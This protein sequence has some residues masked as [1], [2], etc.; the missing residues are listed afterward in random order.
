[1]SDADYRGAIYD[2]AYQGAPGAFSEDASR[3]LLGAAATLL[4]CNSLEDVFR[5]VVDG[6]ASCGVIPISNSIAGAVPDVDALLQ[7]RA[8]TTRGEISVRI[9]QALVGLGGAKVSDIRRVFSHPVALAQCRRFFQ[10]H[11]GLTPQPAFDTAGA[12]AELVRR[13]C[14]SDAAIA[15]VRAA[16]RWGA[17]VLCEDIQD[18]ADNFTRFVRIERNSSRIDAACRRA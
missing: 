6:R 1:M 10:S 7:R 16:E 18:C 13:G 4:P 3:T 11:P 15:S 14:G 5:A 2:C 12:V 9:S 8:V 17:I